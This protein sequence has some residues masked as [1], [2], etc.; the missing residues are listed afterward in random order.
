MNTMSKR[1][2]Q[3]ANST[4]RLIIASVLMMA[5]GAAEMATSFTHKFFGLTTTAATLSTILGTFLGIC[6]FASGVLILS[7]KKKPA[8]AAIALLVVDVI[9]RVLMVI[10]GLYPVDSAL[11]AFA[12]VIGTLIVLLFILYVRFEMRHFI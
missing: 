10:A 1:P 6:Y 5:F 11:Q 9:G 7:R 3:V 2:A 8:M 12:I 4:W